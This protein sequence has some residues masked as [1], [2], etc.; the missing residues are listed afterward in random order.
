MQ[1]PDYPARELQ[2]APSPQ[3]RGWQCPRYDPRST[4]ETARIDA[5]ECLTPRCRRASPWKEQ[6]RTVEVSDQG[7]G[8]GSSKQGAVERWLNGPSL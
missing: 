7:F 5:S 4:M 3:T 8:T 6:K 1:D 2:M